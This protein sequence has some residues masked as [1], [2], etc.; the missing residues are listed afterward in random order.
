MRMSPF[1]E[2]VPG[3]GYGDGTPPDWQGLAEC[4]LVILVGVTG[5]G[6]STTIEAMGETLDFTLLPNRRALT[7]HLIIASMQ[8]ADGEPVTPIVDRRKR[9]AYTRRYRAENA[10]GMAHALTG[11]SVDI[12]EHGGLLVFDGLRGVNEVSFAAE[13]LPYAIF[14]L[15][16]APD[17]VRVER[18][19]GRNDA[20]DR[21]DGADRT[22]NADR[23]ISFAELGLPEAGD[24]FDQAEEARLLALIGS[25]ETSADDLIAKLRIV[26]EERRNYDPAATREA[27]IDLAPTRTLA[28]DTTRNSPVEAAARIARLF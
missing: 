13:A 3:I 8:M 6:K 1:E 25:A 27:L 26:L 7:D 10:G 11:L 12:D 28:I 22:A 2:I 17:V 16:E 5:V 20:F 4:P 14:V 19:L 9:F 24:L 23:A 21:I 18:L 15:L